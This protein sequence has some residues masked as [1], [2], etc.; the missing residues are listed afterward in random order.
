M[1]RTT[2]TTAFLLLFSATISAQSADLAV[3]GV[4]YGPQGLPLSG[5]E[6]VLL[7]DGESLERNTTKPNGLF[8][9]ALDFDHH[10]ELIVRKS[11]YKPQK[12]LFNTKELSKEEKDFTY[13]LTRIRLTL[14]EGI[15]DKDAE[16]VQDF[17]FDH[18]RGN[19]RNQ[20]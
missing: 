8:N 4:V 14:E 1:I 16:V 10:Y 3:S 6:Q 11:G 19:F 13:K 20:P 17:K 15:A 5:V 12:L 2:I 7:R 18:E 9:Y